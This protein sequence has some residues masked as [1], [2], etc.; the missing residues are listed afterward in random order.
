VASQEDHQAVCTAS[1]FTSPQGRGLV[2]QEKREEVAG[3][4]HAINCPEGLRRDFAIRTK[5]GRSDM[6]KGGVREGDEIHPQVWQSSDNLEVAIAA[7]WQDFAEMSA[8]VPSGKSLMTSF[9]R[10]IA[11]INRTTSLEDS[12]G[13]SWQADSLTLVQKRPNF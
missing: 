2:N 6:R 13:G 11:R 12:P 10:L 7:T 1:E 3:L 8:C 5:G 4:Q 9:G